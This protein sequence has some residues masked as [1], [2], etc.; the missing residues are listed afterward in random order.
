M[1]QSAHI[2]ISNRSPLETLSLEDQRLFYQHGW[3]PHV[4]PK[5]THLIDAFQEQVTLHPD[6]IAAIHDG[7]SITYQELDA[8]ANSLAWE[9]NRTGIGRGHT[10][11]LFVERSIEMLV[12]IIGILKTGAAY[13]PQQVA[14]T[15]QGH[16][17]HI[18]KVSD[19][20]IVLTLS[21]Y[22][23]QLSN[24][25]SIQA[26]E[27]DRFL[28]GLRHQ[29]SDPPFVRPAQTLPS[30]PCYLLFTSGSTGVPN[31]VSVSHANLCNILLTQ[32]GGL[33][34]RPGTR[35]SQLLN[36]AFDMAA[37]EILGC[38]MQGGTLVIRGKNIQEAASQ[39]EVIIATPSILA[40]LDPRLCPR[41]KTVAVAGETCPPSLAEAWSARCIFYNS[42]GPTEVTIVNT[43]QLVRPGTKTLSIG[44]PTPNNTVYILDQDLR[45]CAIGEKGEIWAGGDC[46]SLGY[47]KNPMLNQDRYRPD[48]FLGGGRMMFRT[49]DVGRWNEEGELEH[50]GRTDEQVKIRGFRVELASI[51]A[52]LEAFAG[53]TQGVA[54]KLNDRELIAFVRP[55][56]LHSEELRDWVAKHLPYYCVPSLIVPLDE[57]PMTPRGKVDRVALF[58]KAQEILSVRFVEEAC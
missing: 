55:A 43:M 41:V 50:H 16:L 9:L 3:G 51:G 28:S 27:L 15:P 5:H 56:S 34:I 7:E 33:G 25:S 48:P 4:R 6:S 12:G 13:V 18:L 54:V 26:L 58:S 14:L 19:T 36:I 53:C 44:K 21:K 17:D 10:V 37:W 52:V 38:L 57:F 1:N 31:G 24:R 39:A 2:S 35:V 22:L 11:G 32:P 40:T 45:P 49:R 42:C 29:A 46:V 47:L 8:A 20:K 23:H 30:D